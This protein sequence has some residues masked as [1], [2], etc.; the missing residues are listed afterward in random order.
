LRVGAVPGIDDSRASRQRFD[1][2]L[3]SQH[4][5]SGDSRAGS[6]HGNVE[7]EFENVT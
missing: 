1:F 5:G 7:I 2:G 3:E 6:R 4:L